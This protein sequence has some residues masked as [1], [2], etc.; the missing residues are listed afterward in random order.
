MRTNYFLKLLATMLLVFL[1]TN[2]TAKQITVTEPATD[3]D[4]ATALEQ[5]ENGDEIVI[6]GFVEFSAPVTVTKNVTFVGASE[7]AL[8]DGFDGLGESKIFELNPDPIEGQKLV[9]RNLGFFGGYNAGDDGGIGRILTGTTEFYD[10]ILDG[11]TTEHRGGA[12]YLPSP[13]GSSAA[14]SFHNCEITNNISTERGGAFFVTG[15]SYT[16]SFDFCKIQ[17]NKSITD[18]GGAFF[19]EGTNSNNF[20]Y[21][22]IQSNTS[23]VEGEGGERGGGAFVTAGDHSAIT[24]ESCAIVSN[25]A[26]GNHGSTFF[27]MGSPNITLIN[28]VV[29]NNVTKAGAGSWF[30]ASGDCDI[31]LVNTIMTKNTGGNSGNAG[32]GLRVMNTNNRINLFNSLVLG[33]DTYQDNTEGA[34]DLR[35]DNKVGIES[36]WVFK[37]SIVGLISGLEPARIPAPQDKAG[38]NPSLINMYNIGGESAQPDWVALDLS[39]IDYNSQPLVTAEFGMPYYTLQ[40]ADVYAAKMGDPALLSDYDLNTD[41]FNETRTVTGG[42]VFAGPVQSVVGGGVATDPKLGIK[43]IL[44]PAKE[45]IRIVGIVSNGILGVDFGNIKGQAKGDL[46]SLTGQSVETVFNR[47]VVGKGYYNVHVQPGIYLLRV[48]NGGNTYVQKVIVK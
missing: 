30:I 3:A 12:F 6:S 38:I 8:Y 11:N 39:G 44:A 9:F 45:N 17:G 47:N 31:T 22:L 33:N 41:M 25:I 20:Y 26:Y 14:V 13:E 35:A 46:I 27:L 36:T 18:R 1:V 48:V 7:D 19:I 28:S 42:A 2:V 4:L 24:L 37:N 16:T 43:Q 15:N 23:G 40:N 10:C 32:G 21:T 34:V 29:A 5:A